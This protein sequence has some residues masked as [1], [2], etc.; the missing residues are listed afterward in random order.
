MAQDDFEYPNAGPFLPSYTCPECGKG[1]GGTT[2]VD[3]YKHMIH[4]L[5]V[6]PDSLERILRN[7]Q[8]ERKEHGDRVAATVQFLIGGN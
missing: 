5:H 4:C 1:S 8:A 6:E 7:A 2:G 3:T